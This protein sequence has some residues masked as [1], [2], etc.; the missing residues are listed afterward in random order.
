MDI[1]IYI[2]EQLKAGKTAQEI[3][4][5]MTDALNKEEQNAKKEE[6]VNKVLN[7]LDN[8][9]DEYNKHDESGDLTFRDVGIL[10][11]IVAAGNTPEKWT[12]QQ[13]NNYINSVEKQAK[14]AKDVILKSTI[15]KSFTD[16]FKD[17]FLYEKNKDKDEDLFLKWLKEL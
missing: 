15:D 11:L 16:L 5:M 13:M 2:Q 1:S 7:H 17:L 12:I 6:A 14:W 4:K 9:V 3:A 10:A 8:L